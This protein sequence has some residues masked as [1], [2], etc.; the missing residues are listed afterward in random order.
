MDEAR[1]WA[2]TLA[3]AFGGTVEEGPPVESC[4]RIGTTRSS[5]VVIGMAPGADRRPGRAL[6]TLARSCPAPLLFVPARTDSIEGR[7]D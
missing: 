5:V 3:A 4:D 7:H 1:L 6:T 2:Q